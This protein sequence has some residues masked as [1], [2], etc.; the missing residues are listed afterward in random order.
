MGNDLFHLMNARKIQLIG[1]G[2]FAV[3]IITLI[4]GFLS[5]VMD[6]KELALTVWGTVL[7]V[8][9]LLT[10]VYSVVFSKY[11]EHSGRRTLSGIVFILAAFFAW[12]VPLID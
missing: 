12:S 1:E 5:L 7:P 9:F 10:G 2:F 8:I 4:L 3:I 6:Q 11:F